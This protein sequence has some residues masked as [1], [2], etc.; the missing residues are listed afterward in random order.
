MKNL[1]RSWNKSLH[2]IEGGL[3]N[4]GQGLSH[5]SSKIAGGMTRSHDDPDFNAPPEIAAVPSF[6][7]KLNSRGFREE[8]MGGVGGSVP[9]GAS[10]ATSGADRTPASGGGGGVGGVGGG[11]GSNGMNTM[12]RRPTMTSTA[13]TGSL[14]RG[15]H[16]ECSTCVG[17]ACDHQNMRRSSPAPHP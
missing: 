17:C 6:V 9:H 16:V 8:G 4:F 13:A 10:G 11:G 1:Q 2:R 5:V 14:V 12:S 3:M 7:E 15:L